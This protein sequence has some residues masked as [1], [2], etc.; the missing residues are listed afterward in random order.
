[1]MSILRQWMWCLLLC[2]GCATRQPFRPVL[3]TPLA[4]RSA[5]DVYEAVRSSLPTRFTLLTSVVFE[6]RRRSMTALGFTQVDT[7][8]GT[9]SVVAMSPMGVKLFELHGDDSS[10]EAV[11]VA[12]ELTQKADPIDMIGGDVHTVYF[13][14]LPARS[15]DCRKETNVVVFES[16]DEDGRVEY[17]LGGSPPVLVEKRLCD[18]HG[19][20]WRVTYHEYVEEDGKLYPGGIV[21]RHCRYGYRLVIR[22][23][24]IVEPLQRSGNRL[25][26]QK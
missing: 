1:M 7:D 10:V 2:T 16:E 13:N 9:F 12:R 6:Y 23:K 24:Q 3:L 20:V 19:A 5:K 22:L 21:M 11:L 4:P 25:E 18:E 26:G 17:V 8:A 15:A 14:L